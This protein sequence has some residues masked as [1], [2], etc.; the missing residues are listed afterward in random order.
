MNNWE[1]VRLGEVVKHRKKFIQ[2]DDTKTYKRCKVQA[3]MKG[4]VERDEVSGYEIKTKSQQ[5]CQQ[6]DFIVAKIDAK[7]GGYGFV[8]GE[9]D[10]AVVSSHY[11][12]YEIDGQKIMREYLDF[13]SKTDQFF[14]QVKA[15]GSTNYA[16]IRPHNVLGYEIPLPPLIEQARIV[17]RLEGLQR[18]VAEVRALRQEQAALMAG[19]V[20]GKFEEITAEARRLPLREVAPLTR[21]P[22]EVKPD[23]EY[24]ELGVR[25]FGRGTF[26]KP[27]V[28]GSEFTWQKPYWLHAGDLL[29]SNIKAWEGAVAVVQPADHGRIGSHRYLTCVADEAVTSA[30]FL[31]YFL[32]TPEGLTRLGDA[33][34]GT[35]DRNRT[36]NTGKLGAIPVPIPSL[37]QQRDFMAL[38]QKAEAMR[39][40]TAEGEAL[41]DGLLP[42][43]LAEVFGGEES[44]I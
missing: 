11:F 3:N 36:L 8:P 17:A 9:L 35:A 2:I 33:S 38:L 20:A 41:L 30:E 26:H 1:R 37:A 27:N 15:Q 13:F 6:D 24:R 19:L 25:S 5:V 34:P 14:K 22:V 42:G 10:G 12:L 29:L 40:A 28:L 39:A 18:R 21:R 44:I 23:E 32:L 7:V 31:L 4:V 43:V 16:A